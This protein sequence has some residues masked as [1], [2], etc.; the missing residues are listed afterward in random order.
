MS[1]LE[2][3]AERNIKLI[4]KSLNP[5]PCLCFGR[6]P[7]RYRGSPHFIIASYE[8]SSRNTVDLVIFPQKIVLANNR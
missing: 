6:I 3:A 1:E 4:M 5:Y 7:K 2:S 8:I